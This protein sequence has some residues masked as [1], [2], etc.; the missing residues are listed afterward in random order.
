MDTAQLVCHPHRGH[1]IIPRLPLPLATAASAFKS[2]V[3]NLTENTLLF[4]Q[5]CHLLKLFVIIKKIRNKLSYLQYIAFL[6]TS[7]NNMY[8]LIYSV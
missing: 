3:R 5:V 7:E 8:L 4:M 1:V 6:S 2:T